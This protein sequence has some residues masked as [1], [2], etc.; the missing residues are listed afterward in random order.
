MNLIF[1]SKHT[2]NL[3]AAYLHR[4]LCPSLRQVLNHRIDYVRCFVPGV[5]LMLH[6]IILPFL[7][8]HLRYVLDYITLFDGFCLE[9]DICLRL[10]FSVAVP[11]GELP[12][13]EHRL[14][15]VGIDV[16]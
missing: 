4:V 7:L 14:N 12:D 11:R 6:K 5:G 3:S 9:G 15:F 8:R 16:L 10:R 13:A 1:A 2:R